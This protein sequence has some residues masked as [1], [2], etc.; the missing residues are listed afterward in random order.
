MDDFTYLLEE[1]LLVFW[2]EAMQLLS[3]WLGE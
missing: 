3:T 1:L 2:N